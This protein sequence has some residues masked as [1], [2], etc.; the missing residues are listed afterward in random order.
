MENIRRKSKE[1]LKHQTIMH[2]SHQYINFSFTFSD[3]K[4]VGHLA[5]RLASGNSACDPKKILMETI[6]NKINMYRP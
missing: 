6:N 4:N 2:A 3:I 1:V 5:V